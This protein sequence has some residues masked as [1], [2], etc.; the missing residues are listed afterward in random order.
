MD[1]NRCGHRNLPEA[2]YCIHCGTPMDMPTISNQE[3]EDDR[4]K[5]LVPIIVILLLII[6]GLASIIGGYVYMRGGLFVKR[7]PIPTPTPVVDVGSTVTEQESESTQAPQITPTPAPVVTPAPEVT[8]SPVG[9][10]DNDSGKKNSFLS[11][12]GQIEMY[13][14]RNLETAMAQQDINRESGVVYQKWD[15]LLNEV[16]QYLK[17]TMSKSEF[18]QLKSD[19]M[20][21]VY[22]KEAAI[23]EE[24]SY[25]E[26]GS[27]EAMARNMTGIDYT[28]KRCY[29][30]I[31][32][33]D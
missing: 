14:K 29:Y 2:R 26:G 9:V 7:E 24:A 19:E 15:K 13:A 27:G 21:W 23:E 3:D 30:L 25:W 11:K 1:C 20:A 4:G 31:S 22:E 5:S 8:Q 18:E 12:A 17:A 6:A 10:S 16:Y 32:L 33:I 28:S